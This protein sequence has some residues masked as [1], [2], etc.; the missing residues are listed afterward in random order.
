MTKPRLLL[1]LDGSLRWEAP[2]HSAHRRGQEGALHFCTGATEQKGVN[3]AKN[4]HCVLTT[5]R[6]SWSTGLDVAVEGQ[7]RRV[8]DAGRL[9]R[10]AAGW[11]SKYDGDWHFEVVD[12]GFRGTPGP[13]LVF[14]VVPTTILAFAK[15]NFAQT[16]YRF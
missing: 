8:T 5:G 10:L 11:D 7:A 9:K 13:V 14:E 15:G 4:S 6:N 16:R 12:G 1:D 2:C 3:L